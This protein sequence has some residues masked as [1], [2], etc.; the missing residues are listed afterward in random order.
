M[1]W[2]KCREFDKESVIRLVYEHDFYVEL[3]TPYE[4]LSILVSSE[5]CIKDRSNRVQDKISNSAS[6]IYIYIYI[7]IIGYVLFFIHI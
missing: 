5:M 7:Y 1:Q 3:K 2:R 6:R 4:L